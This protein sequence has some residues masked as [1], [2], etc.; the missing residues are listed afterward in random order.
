VITDADAAAEKDFREDRWPASLAL[1]VCVFLYLA[2]PRVL[3]IEPR[4]LV[5]AL[6]LLPLIP[7]SITHRRL[8]PGQPR[9][10]RPLMISLIALINA[11]NLVSIYLLVH[12]LLHPGKG[13]VD[14]R[15]LVYSAVLVWVTNVIVFSLWFWELDRGGPATRNTP[16]ERWPDFQFPQ[17]ENPRLAQPNW[18]PRYIDYFYVALTNGSAFS[19]TDAMPLTRLAKML[20][21]AESTASMVVVIVV[22]AR[23]V[24]ILK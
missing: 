11:A 12:H 17:M 2:L 15:V 3:I 1:I 8:H 22:A 18:R 24:N 13:G 23:A 10:T 7:L 21:A 16:H 20:M 5:P 6:E 4:W 9:W 19:P 14:G